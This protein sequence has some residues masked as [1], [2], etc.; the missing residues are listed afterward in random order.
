MDF[1]SRLGDA[2]SETSKDVSQKVADF[3]GIARL[4]MDIR[5]R[6]ELVRKQYL[7]IGKQYYEMHKEDVEPFFEEIRLINET[8]AEIDQLKAKIADLKGKKKCSVCGAVNEGE[9]AYCSKCGAKCES[10][11]ADDM[12]EQTEDDIQ[13][14]K[15]DIVEEVDI[16]EVKEELVQEENI[17][18]ELV[19]KANIQDAKEDFTEEVEE[20]IVIVDLE[21]KTEE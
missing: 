21:K 12:P 1:F 14:V 4:N 3:T 2:I 18:E 20:D 16:Q 5:N 19:E 10:I 11:F 7:E 9:A 15:E 6:E 8:L 17:Q 13:E